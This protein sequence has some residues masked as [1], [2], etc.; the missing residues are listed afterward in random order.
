MAQTKGQR[1]AEGFAIADGVGEADRS[2][3]RM[4]IHVQGDVEDALAGEGMGECDRSIRSGI[5][6]S[7]STCCG[8]VFTEDR[9]PVGRAVVPKHKAA[10]LCQRVLNG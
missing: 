2:L 6:K 8:R 7:H 10:F 4:A 9:L 5:K 3:L 1:L